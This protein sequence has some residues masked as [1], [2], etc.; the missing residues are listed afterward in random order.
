MVGYAKQARGRGRAGVEAEVAR[1]RWASGRLPVP[2]VLGSDEGTWSWMVTSVLE[3]APVSELVR[4]WEPE[5]T[6][7]RLVAALRELHAQPVDACPFDARVASLMDEARRN[8]E[9][10]W[11]DEG[12]FDPERQGWT[13]AQVLAELERSVPRCEE[14]TVTHGDPCLPNLLLGET[15]RHGWI[16]VGALG[17]GDRHRDLA[18]VVRSAERN[19]GAG[20]GRRFLRAYGLPVDEARLSFFTLLDEL[21]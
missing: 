14:L 4:Q 17:V 18:L 21:F 20:W 9:M 2:L 10:G 12:D 15:G 11:V 3:G 19:L 5:V 8:V 13:G 16:D 1:L 7:P 6:I